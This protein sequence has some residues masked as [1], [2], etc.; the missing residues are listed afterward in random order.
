MHIFIACPWNPNGGGMFKVADYL[1]QC[2]HAV[3]KG[4]AEEHVALCALDTRGEGSALASMG[5]LVLALARIAKNRISGQLKGVHVNMA[6]RLSLFR[7]AVVVVF[8]RAIGL[9]VVL[10]LHAAQLHH[11]YLSLIHI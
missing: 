5:M 8:S 4:G 9:P 2:Q 6:E 10:H 1:I 3:V 11:F 7:K